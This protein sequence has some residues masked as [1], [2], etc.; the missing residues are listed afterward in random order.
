M[1]TKEK[2]DLVVKVAGI[3]IEEEELPEVVREV[4]SITKKERRWIQ[5]K[6]RELLNKEH[7]NE[8]EEE[9][10]EKEKV[11]ETFKKALEGEE[12]KE[13]IFLNYYLKRKQVHEILNVVDE[14]MKRME[15]ENMGQLRNA[16][17]AATNTAKE[18]VGMKRRPNIQKVSSLERRIEKMDGGSR[19][20]P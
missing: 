13:D 5:E 20:L 4:K 2:I 14:E 17:K 12:E 15:F 6:V 8:E 11:I 10:I 3:V 16:V 19:K 9:K 7:K 18:L 1:S